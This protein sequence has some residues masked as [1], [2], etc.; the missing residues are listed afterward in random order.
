MDD[1]SSR[2]HYRK[3]LLFHLTESQLA[4]RWWRMIGVLSIGTSTVAF[5]VDLRMGNLES[6]QRGIVNFFDFIAFVL[7]ILSHIYLPLTWKTVSSEPALKLKKGPH[8]LFVQ[9]L[10]NQAKLGNMKEDSKENT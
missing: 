10:S 9:F 3:L 7:V 2:E 4:S 8:S 6:L 1:N 5:V